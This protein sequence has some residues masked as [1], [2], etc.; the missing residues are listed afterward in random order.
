[1][2]LAIDDF[3][4]RDV[5]HG[6]GH[7][8]RIVAAA[9]LPDDGLHQLALILEPLALHLQPGAKLRQANVRLKID[10]PRDPGDR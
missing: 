8:K 6:N 10:Q 9:R 1:M 4:R 3:R 2:V 7:D 5:A